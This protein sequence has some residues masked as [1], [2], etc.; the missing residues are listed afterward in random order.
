MK[1]IA[2]LSAL[3]KLINRALDKLDEFDRQRKQLQREERRASVQ[4]NPDKAFADLFGKPGNV[5]LHKPI[6]RQAINDPMRADLSTITVD[7]NS[8]GSSNNA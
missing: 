5:Q 4:A 8:K 7:K 1:L 3:F 6:N 2:L